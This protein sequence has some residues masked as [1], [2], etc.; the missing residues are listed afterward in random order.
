MTANVRVLHDGSFIRP[1]GSSRVAR[2][3]ARA[4]DAPVTVGH[5]VD[6]AFWADVDAE[7]PFQDEFHRGLSG[8][9]YERLPKHYAE[10]RVGQRY[11]ELDFEEEILLS[12]STMSKWVVPKYYQTHVNYCH[13][14]PPHFYA[15]PKRGVFDWAKSLGLGMVDQHFTT[16]VDRVLANSEFTRRRIRKHYRREAPVLHPPIRVDDFYYAE[17]DDPPY[18]VMVCRLVPMKRVETVA[19]AFAGIDGARLV[20]V[21]D[22]PLR[23]AVERHE[24]VTVRTG[25]S[26]EAVEEVVARS[27]GGVAFAELEHCGMTPKEFQA[28]G[29]PVV[30]PDEPNLRN[31]VTDGEDGVVVEV[32]EAGVRD[33]VRRVL[34]STWD[35]ER[36][37][38]TAAP[39]DAERFRERARELVRE[40][41]SD[42]P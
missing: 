22:G 14:P 9:V 21:G 42:D 7:F 6:R 20:V 26:D 16:F 34:D 39:W 28:A 41:T 11:R 13:V 32:S 1:G 10:F 5:T 12:T 30:V 19:R 18:F 31:H 8:R 3:L 38:Q 24:N 29:K 40:A 36:I 2:E 4:F 35:P 33:G 25:L 37:R 15:V 17:P 27:V 23:D